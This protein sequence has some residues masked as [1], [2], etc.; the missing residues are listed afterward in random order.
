MPDYPPIYILRHGQTEWNLQRRYQGQMNSDLTALG[1]AQAA[2]QGVLLHPC[3]MRIQRDKSCAAL[4][5]AHVKPQ[6]SH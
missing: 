3:L 2:D 1:R 6:I 5:I 4:K